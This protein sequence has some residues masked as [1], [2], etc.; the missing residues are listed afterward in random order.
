MN[1]YLIERKYPF[2]NGHIFD[3]VTTSAINARNAINNVKNDNPDS[4]ILSVYIGDE[5][6]WELIDDISDSPYSDFIDCEYY[7]KSV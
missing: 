3:F 5:T 4:I 7:Y 2:K 1:D 6:G